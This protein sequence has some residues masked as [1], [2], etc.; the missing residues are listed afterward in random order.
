L[1]QRKPDPAG[2]GLRRAAS[3]ALEAVLSGRPFEPIGPGT[4]PEGRDRAI[5][6]RLVTL[7]LRHHGQ[8]DI[9]LDECLDKGLPRKA[10]SFE[11]VVRIAIAQLV[12]LP[13]LGAHSAL[14]LAVETLKRDPKARHLSGLI[15]AVLRRVQ[16]NSAR[17]GTMPDREALPP[18]VVA[19]WSSIYGDGF[20]DAMAEALV[21]GA[22]LDLTLK[23]PD[24]EL[25]ET[26][27]ADPLWGPS[28]RIT[29]RDRTVEA[30]PGYDEGAWWVQDAAAA[31]PATLLAL[32]EGARVL[33]L[34]A[35][36]GGKT[37]QLVAA[38][39]AVTALDAD[40]TRIDRLRTNLDRLGMSPEIV[41]ADAT[42]FTPPEPFDA[43]LLDA[44]C[45]ATGTFRRHPEVLWHR[46]AADIAS[47]VALQRTLLA[48]AATMLEPGGTL[49][50]AVCSLEP[51]EGEDQQ[52]WALGTLTEL[53]AAPIAPEDVALPDAVTAAGALRLHPGLVAGGMDGFFVARF[54]RRTA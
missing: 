48:K 27:G 16:A 22:V 37:A 51:E 14:F 26:L 36:P 9:I 47:R 45:S 46:T 29:D 38:G 30:L 54:R 20:V 43:V 25:V 40:P 15:N 3:A 53:E 13:D 21:T 24:P 31:I 19:R 33:D 23:T 39:Y 1:A 41:M 6:N 2:L 50:Y 34:C 44:P 8:I 42:S 7:A 28:V 17:Y 52:R 49:I 11:A 5:A 10:G 32:P 18:A 4:L 35:A 12:Y